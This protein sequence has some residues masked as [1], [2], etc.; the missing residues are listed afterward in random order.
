MNKN[1]IKGRNYEYK[2]I[3]LLKKQGY[4]CVRSA[5]SHKVID[6]V[7]FLQGEGLEADIIKVIQVKS[8][9]S[10]YKQDLAKLKK[11]FLPYTVS[12]ELWLWKP[13][14]KEPMVILIKNN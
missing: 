6:I 10:P 4:Y 12:K 2:T 3:Q 1:Y 5:G 11:L 14:K 8:G 13:R 9:N 7:A